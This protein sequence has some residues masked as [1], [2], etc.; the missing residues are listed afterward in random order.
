M[1]GFPQGWISDAPDAGHRPSIVTHSAAK[2]ILH[3]GTSFCCERASSP[4][5]RR[6]LREA[7]RLR[8]DDPDVLNNLGTA[9]WQ[10][11][12]TAEATAYYLRAHQFKPRDFGILNNLGIALWDQ[13][14]PERAVAFLSPGA[15]DSARLVRHADEPGRRALRPGAVRRGSDWLRSSLAM[16]PDSPDAWDN[17]GMTLARQ[18]HWDEAMACYD[19]AI[20]LRPDF[21]EAHRNRALGWLAHGDFERGWPEAEWR[22]RCRNRPVLRL[23]A[24]ALD[25]RGPDG[26][27]PSC[28]TGNKGLATPCS[29]SA[30]PRWSRSEGARC[31]SVPASPRAGWSLVSRRRSRPRRTTTAAGFSRC[32]RRS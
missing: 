19:R 27:A 30:S 14:R 7:L 21:G 6:A 17:V 1:A 3:E 23:P 2:Q 31:G 10:Q 20:G 18:G 26:P 4:R 24:P 29:S 9:V 8:P 28:S 22:L 11:G 16:K 5:L 15:R 32:T 25:R 13:G 12:R